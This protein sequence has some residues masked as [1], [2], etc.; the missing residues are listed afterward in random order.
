MVPQ[1]VNI[2][3][4]NDFKFNK[5]FAFF[6]INNNKKYNFVLQEKWKKD[7]NHLLPNYPLKEDNYYGNDTPFLTESKD[8]IDEIAKAFFTEYYG[9]KI[10]PELI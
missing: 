1:N 10:S 4:F 6:G 5:D 9:I 2:P 8:N 3:E 7:V